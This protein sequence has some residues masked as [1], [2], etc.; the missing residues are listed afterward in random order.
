M[1]VKIGILIL[2]A[3]VLLAASCSTTRILAEDEYLLNKNSITASGDKGFNAKTLSGDI[4]QKPNSAILGLRPLV[5][6]YN[7][8]G[9]FWK[10]MGEAPVIYDSTL[11]DVSINNIR[12][13]L[14]YMGYY[15]SVVSAETTFSGKKADVQYDVRLG[16]RYPISSIRYDLPDRGEFTA[17]F[18]RDTSRVSIKVGDY[19]SEEKLE[20]ETVR[21]ATLL[22]NRGYFDF[23]RNNYF[24]EADTLSHPGYADLIYSVR[25]YTRTEVEADAEP[26]RKFYIGD[27]SITRDS[28]L[29]FRDGLL[30]EMNGV[31]PGQLYRE[32][33]VDNTYS[34]IA[35][36]PCFGSVNIQMTQV[37]TNRV[38]CNIDLTSAQMQGFKV[39]FEASVNS[40][41]LIGISPQLTYFHQNFFHG[42]ERFNLGLMGN[43]QFQPRSDTRATELGVSSSILFPR[44]LGIPGRKFRGTSVPR[45][46][47]T[48]SYNYQNRPE[49]TL[50]I[51]SF[52]YA[53][54]G[55]TLLW[56]QRLNYQITPLQLSRIMVSHLDPDF[57]AKVSGNPSV[58]SLFTSHINA[59][60]GVDFNLTNTRDAI[61]QSDYHNLRLSFESGGNLISLFNPILKL[62][63]WE[64]TDEEGHTEIIPLDQHLF[65]GVPYSQFVKG[66]FQYAKAFYFGRN[67]RQSFAF[68]LVAGAGYGYGNST[69]LPFEKQFWAGGASSM[70]G[71]QARALGPGISDLSEYF[72]IANQTGDMKLEA[73]L[74]YRF[75]IV[76]IL[77]G[78]LFVDAG[79]IWNL[80]SP[81]VVDVGDIFHFNTLRQSVAVNYGLGIRADLSFLLARV[82]VG[83]QLH[84]PILTEHAWALDPVEMIKGRHF[85]IHFGIGYPF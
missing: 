9:Q 83:F 67:D 49:Y 57:L 70:R 69:S 64:Y 54:A 80:P 12:N 23:D 72:A 48:L 34:R 62:D 82:D 43:F 1:K 85:A 77:H 40:S 60:V 81:N 66:E 46:S 2:S 52:S 47:M 7:L 59:G 24:F 55:Y 42:G 45:T 6:V 74:E 25:E 37:D 16:R 14:E 65:L 38:D 63:S 13:R 22:R 58:F 11:V 50:S 10:K 84:N 35:A 20:E 28:T 33:T 15:G 36:L 5:A 29:R 68:R 39:D 19:L 27:V 26:I 53:Y 3:G 32:V 73:N 44:L 76:S 21:S 61:P 18:L 30:A 4:R 8:D 75:P 71:W 31:I 78:A 79:N 51:L 17:D 41:G 56:R